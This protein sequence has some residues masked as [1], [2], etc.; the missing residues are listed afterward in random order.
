M[1]SEE[2]K[3]SE[4]IKKNKETILCMEYN[5]VTSRMYHL[6]H[7]QGTPFVRD[8]ELEVKGESIHIDYIIFLSSPIFFY[9][10][11]SNENEDPEINKIEEHCNK[12]NIKLIICYVKEDNSNLIV[13][14]SAAVT[15]LLSGNFDLAVC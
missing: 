14:Y 7:G 15:L 3:T 12:A 13:S 11:L 1:A 4:Q 9:M 10:T 2:K 8:T 6:L 5:S